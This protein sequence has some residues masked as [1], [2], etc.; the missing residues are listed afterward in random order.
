MGH[1][2]QQPQPQGAV[3]STGFAPQ[4]QL[5]AEQGFLQA[6]DGTIVLTGRAMTGGRSSSS[7]S[8][9]AVM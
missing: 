3:G 5:Q 2:P 4:T 7:G 8:G 9:C 6:N 1:T